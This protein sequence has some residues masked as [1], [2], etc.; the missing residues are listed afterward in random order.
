MK[1][2]KNMLRIGTFLAILMFLL[3][4]ALSLHVSAAFIQPHGT[5]STD[6][7]TTGPTATGSTPTGGDITDSTPYDAQFSLDYTYKDSKPA[8][9]GGTGSTH[10]MV[11]HIWYQRGGIGQYI[12]APSSQS[13]VNIA[14]GGGTISNTYTTNKITGYGG[15]GTQ[16]DVIVEVYCKDT[17]TSVTDKW[18]GPAQTY[19]VL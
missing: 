10:W 16:F 14:A 12:Y 1:T 3:I 4:P 9:S 18:V 11:V 5:A 15:S 7:T 8:G 17:A 6:N 19:L 2:K 13:P